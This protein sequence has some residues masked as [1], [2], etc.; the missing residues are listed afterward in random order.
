MYLIAKNH[1]HKNIKLRTYYVHKRKTYKIFNNLM[2]QNTKHINQLTKIVKRLKTQVQIS[3]IQ[4]VLEP[5]GNQNSTVSFCRI[6]WC[7]SFT[8][9]PV[10]YIF[11][12]LSFTSTRTSNHWPPLGGFWPG[13]AADIPF[14][15]VGTPFSVKPVWKHPEELCSLDIMA[16]SSLSLFTLTSP[17]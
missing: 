6:V 2:Q 3:E 14:V 13:Q 7:N 12:F 9:F 4:Y 1:F 16:R 5:V 11:A 17:F 15:N 10:K 8:S